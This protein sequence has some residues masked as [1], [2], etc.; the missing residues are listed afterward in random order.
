MRRPDAVLTT[1]PSIVLTGLLLERGLRT[2]SLPESVPPVE[3][4]QF[5]VLGLC[6]AFALIVY[7]VVQAPSLE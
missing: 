2:V 1:I 4:I 5:T 7:E 3:W 6:L